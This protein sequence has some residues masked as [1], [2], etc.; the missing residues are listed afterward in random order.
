MLTCASRFQGK[1]DTQLSKASGTVVGMADW[2]RR[3]PEGVEYRGETSTGFTLSVSLPVGDDGLSPLVCPKHND[4]HFKVRVVQG[5]DSSSSC[6]CAY[7]GHFATTWDFM[8]AQMDR[9]LD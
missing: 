1:S 3:L 9:A 4:H 6:Y 7:C 8:P 2:K 5:G